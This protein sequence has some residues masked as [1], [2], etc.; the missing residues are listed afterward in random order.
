MLLISSRQFIVNMI[1]NTKLPQD[2]IIRVSDLKLNTIS[3]RKSRRGSDTS[4]T[5]EPVDLNS[6]ATKKT[7]SA[8]KMEKFNS[9][10]FENF[11]SSWDG[12]NLF[13]CRPGLE[14]CGNFQMDA[15]V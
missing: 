14:R 12:I 8:G 7:A 5:D 4:A 13:K 3:R 9:F 6:F 2:Q 1:H 10:Y 11:R 15:F